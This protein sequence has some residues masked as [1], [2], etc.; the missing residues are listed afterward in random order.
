MLRYR[1]HDDIAMLCAFD[2]IELDGKSLRWMAIE[3]R[4]HALA[5]LL[6]WAAR[7]DRFQHTL[8]GRRRYHLQPRLPLKIK[9]PSAPG[10]RREA[11]EDWGAKRW[12]RGR[13]V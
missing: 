11:E 12:A 9:N 13:R 1:R 2:L 4:Q 5:E 7:R 8:R 3:H 10:V 6:K